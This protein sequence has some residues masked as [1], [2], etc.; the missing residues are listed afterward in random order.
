MEI[1]KDSDVRTAYQLLKNAVTHTPLQYDRY[2]SEKYQANV[3]FKREDLQKVRSFKLRGAYYA[4]KKLPAAELQK[5]VVCASAGNH[6][7]GVAYTCKELNS[8]AAIFM[9]STTPQ[10]KVS[11]VQFFGGDN[12]E[13]FL[14]GD[15][16]DASATAARKYCEENN[17]TFID[18]F[19]DPN[20]I[21]GQGTLALEM[22]TDAEREGFKPDYVL[23][24]IGG[25]GLISGV[26]SYVKNTSPTTKV[27]GVEPAGAPSMQAAFDNEGPIELNEID[28]FVDGAAVKKVGEITYTHANKYVDGL[29][30]VDEGLV[31]STILEMYGKQA[32]IAEP[33]GAL[34]VAA[35]EP[36]KDEIKGKTVIC[37]ISGG[38][39]DINRMAEIEERSLMYEG[40][41]H[42]FVVSFPQRPG[43]LK[44]FVTEVLGPDDDITRFEYTKKVNRG[45][46]PVILGILL[47]RKEDLPALLKNIE[48]FDPNY[49]D[50]SE[51]QTLYGLLV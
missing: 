10:Q 9:P 23:A 36:L 28:K 51:N 42:Y 48:Q 7:Q 41:K 35:L 4:I 3:L 18:P 37:I 2:L 31:C 21:A 16:F 47:K 24:A 34:S 8:H 40:L 29:V 25:G 5:G 26:S 44:E 27:I 15:T 46:G 45:A 39:N 19:N 38:N 43:A 49:I 50:L 30:T 20:I 13:I 22:M 17:M 32:I 33:A 6:A 11:Q 14:I 1:V 12:V